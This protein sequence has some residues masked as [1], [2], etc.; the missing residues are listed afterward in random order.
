MVW[1]L[2]PIPSNS[3]G[4]TTFNPWMYELSSQIYTSE[5]NPIKVSGEFEDLDSIAIALTDRCPDICDELSLSP[6]IYNSHGFTNYR[7]EKKQRAA[8]TDDE[9]G[10][11][12]E[13]LEKYSS[14]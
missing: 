6:S 3:G 13:L 1:S 7:G 11:L 5:V 4:S 14:K 9:L 2:L 10:T 8:L 12:Y